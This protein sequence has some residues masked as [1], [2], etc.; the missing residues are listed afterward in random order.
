[1]KLDLDLMRRILLRIEEKSE[2]PPR[3]LRVDDF[4]D[5]CDNEYVISLH[6]DLLVDGGYIEV[7]DVSYDGDLKNFAIARLTLKGYTY[8]DAVRN[9]KVWKD[10]KDRIAPFG[11]VA[12]DIIK[13]LATGMIKGQLNM[14]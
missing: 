10:V 14:N 8:L 12:L 13:E 7:M 6:I 3:V 11:N 1:M 4:L 9:A 5:L 2:V